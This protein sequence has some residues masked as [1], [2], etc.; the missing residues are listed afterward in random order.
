MRLVT[1][2]AR[3]S[4][5][6]YIA[7]QSTM[8]LSPLKTHRVEVLAQAKA[9][10]THESAFES[11]DVSVIALLLDELIEALETGRITGESFERNAVRQA[12]TSWSRSAVDA[13]PV[14][15]PPIAPHQ[16]LNTCT[17]LV[18][19]IIDLE[20]RETVARVTTTPATLKRFFDEQ[21]RAQSR[22]PR[23]SHTFRAMWM[24]F[25]CRLNGLVSSPLNFVGNWT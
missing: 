6:P 17:G 11:A 15:R 21:S 4:Y 5:A 1:F 9:R 8:L 22:S 18:A 12:S 7:F 19:G 3:R 14:P 16:A 10:L 25:T 20:S 24:T 23:R 2:V 13:L